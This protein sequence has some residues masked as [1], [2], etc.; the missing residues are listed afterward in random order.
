[1]NGRL[2]PVRLSR[3][4]PPADI[5]RYPVGEMRTILPVAEQIA[6]DVLFPGALDTDKASVVPVDRLDALAAAGLYGLFG[7]RDAGGSDADL[8]TGA[9]VYEALAGG[10]LTT[11][12]VWAQHHSAVSA[13]M[14]AESETLRD[15]WLKPLCS[16]FRRAG[17][18]FA[19]LRR[20][21]PP[22]LTV[23]VGAGVWI[24]DG[25]APW[26]TGWGRIDVVHTAARDS[27]GNVVWLLVDALAGPT[28][29]VEPLKLA[30]VNASATVGVRFVA[31]EVPACRLT[32]TESMESWEVR[33]AGGLAR[34]GAFSLGIARRCSTL[35][36]TSMFDEEIAAC[37]RALDESTSETVVD[38]R[39]WASD[40]ALRSASA[41]VTSG[42]GRSLLVG[43]HA[44][45]LA[46]EAM[47]LLVFGQTPAIRSAQL[48]RIEGTSHGMAAGLEP[49]NFRSGRTLPD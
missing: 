8:V 21:G 24:L 26:V 12:F 44:Q 49:G 31:H 11:A 45:R 22:I 6:E 39:A 30:A 10:C 5:G 48:R 34:N 35:M 13:V 29:Q 17:V 20:P 36:A 19:G 23:R 37:R 9:L 46:R 32:M 42:G 27:D 18:A 2:R 15:E 38:A 25:T 41:L 3:P 14:R 16:G 47:L 1:M 7:P 40:L 4:G 43:E 33:D 28:M